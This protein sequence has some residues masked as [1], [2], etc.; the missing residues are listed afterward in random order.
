M[1][2]WWCFRFCFWECRCHNQEIYGSN[3]EYRKGRVVGQIENCSQ[4]TVTISSHSLLC[5]IFLFE[6]VKKSNCLL[7]N[8]STWW[9][10]WK[11]DTTT[12]NYSFAAFEFQAVN[13]WMA[14]RRHFFPRMI[15]SHSFLTSLLEREF[16]T[17]FFLFLLLSCHD[18][19]TKSGNSCDK[20]VWAFPL[21]RKLPSG[22]LSFIL[23]IGFFTRIPSGC[24][25][26]FESLCSTTTLVWKA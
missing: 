10:Q 1:K 21:V 16:R 14:R 15:V 5:S 8:E 7:Q 11:F 9:I 17:F 25:V 24:V 2:R 26:K 22:V 12:T 20:T 18:I 3:G 23:R 6:I 13:G 19:I 4:T